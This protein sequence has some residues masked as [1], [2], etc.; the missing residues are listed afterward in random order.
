MEALA[1]GV[2]VVTRDLPVLREVFGG[3]ARFGADVPGIAAAL[4]HAL[5]HPDPALRAAGR[6]LAF[7]HTWAE[8][9]QRH[10]AFYRSLEAPVTD[11]PPCRGM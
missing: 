7:R 6:D 10:L 8:A 2:P 1:A 3:A 9:A 4:A 5:D 11:A